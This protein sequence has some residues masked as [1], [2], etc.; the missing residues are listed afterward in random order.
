MIKGKRWMLII[1]GL[2]IGSL[3]SKA[4]TLN[5]I[6]TTD[7]ETKLSGESSYSYH[8]LMRPWN[9]SWSEV[10]SYSFELNLSFP[11][12]ESYE[13]IGYWSLKLKA[14]GDHSGTP[15]YFFSLKDRVNN[16][17]VSTILL[18]TS[19][20][21]NYSYTL[22]STF[23][24]SKQSTSSNL[25]LIVSWSN[26]FFTREGAIFIEQ[27]SL[28]FSSFPEMNQDYTAPFFPNS[29]LFFVLDSFKTEAFFAVT[30]CV[31]SLFALDSKVNISKTKFEIIYDLMPDIIV[32][33]ID[34]GVI[35]AYNMIAGDQ[36][37]SY[38]SEQDLS[39][40][41]NCSTTWDYQFIPNNHTLFFKISLRGTGN[42]LFKLKSISLISNIPS[43]ENEIL[44]VILQPDSPLTLFF[45]IIFLF[46]PV[47]IRLTF[48]AKKPT[49]E[50]LDEE[51]TSE[52]V[53]IED[54]S[55]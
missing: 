43:T 41:I 51:I 44:D 9:Y 12:I 36:Q 25:S 16:H 2:L 39:E 21:N 3:L 38:L 1:I 27:V 47:S 23:S 40:G 4:S 48:F 33:T 7:L 35:S 10:S 50:I 17:V 53:L 26:A 14:S 45:T 54:R 52:V 34:K 37:Q 55:C 8:Q 31:N 49:C 6:A 20:Q 42:W 24:S 28:S 29:S 32:S 22:W 30:I 5:A 18:T 13:G 11:D 46:A 15:G 19:Q